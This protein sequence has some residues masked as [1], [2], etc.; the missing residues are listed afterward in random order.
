MK[1]V[2]HNRGGT[3]ESV[4]SRRIRRQV[5]AK[6]YFD[7]LS[8]TCI[9]SMAT[10]LVRKVATSDVNIPSDQTVWNVSESILDEN[11]GPRLSNWSID[12]FCLN[13]A[14][15]V[16]F[17]H[18]Y[19]VRFQKPLT[20][21]LPGSS[22]S[23]AVPVFEVLT[24]FF[25][26]ISSRIMITNLQAA[27]STVTA[28]RSSQPDR[29]KYDRAVAPS[30]T[31]P[32][33]SQ[34]DNMAEERREC[35]CSVNRQPARQTEATKEAREL[36]IPR[37]ERRDDET[38]QSTSSARSIPDRIAVIAYLSDNVS[39]ENTIACGWYLPVCSRVKHWTR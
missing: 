3:I 36:A 32:E 16:S 19:S 8:A 33:V 13:P 18:R 22:S 6:A 17:S 23:V 11:S 34:M 21:S 15:K 4:G 5:M 35:L 29:R 27:A 20:A 2:K 1:N 12:K 10:L 24:Y 7:F 28:P 25:F 26:G 9:S 39:I 37:L 14:R 31:I 38:H 30:N